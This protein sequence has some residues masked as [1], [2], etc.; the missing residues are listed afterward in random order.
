MDCDPLSHRLS[1]RHDSG[2]RWRHQYSTDMLG[3]DEDQVSFSYKGPARSG[4]CGDHTVRIA[5]RLHHWFWRQASARLEST[6][7]GMY[8]SWSTGNR[9]TAKER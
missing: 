6:T 8:P 5:L 2:L 4:V 3:S 7:S 9:M 1:I